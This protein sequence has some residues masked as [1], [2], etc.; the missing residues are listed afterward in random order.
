MSEF[1][2]GEVQEPPPLAAKPFAV[3]L[4][5]CI[6]FGSLS[7]SPSWKRARISWPPFCCC[8]AAWSPTDWVG[9][10]GRHPLTV[11]G[12]FAWVFWTSKFINLLTNVATAVFWVFSQYCNRHYERRCDIATNEK[13]TERNK[14]F[15]SQKVFQRP[16]MFWATLAF[17]SSRPAPLRPLVRMAPSWPSSGSMLTLFRGDGIAPCRS[18]LTTS[19]PPLWAYSS[20]FLHIGPQSVSG[21][22]R[23]A[24]QTEESCSL[25]TPVFICGLRML[26]SMI[27]PQFHSLQDRHRGIVQHLRH[28]HG[29][30]PNLHHR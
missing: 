14:K 2:N 27:L 29:A 12:R 30:E 17:P 4:I 5:S 24:A 25:S 8:P 21:R 13:L 11:R 20:M 23:D 9:G 15:E 28:R 6:S 1:H 26:L 7:N 3:F 16:W 22:L 10:A 18:M 19:W